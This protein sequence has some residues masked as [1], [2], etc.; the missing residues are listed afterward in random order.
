MALTLTSSPNPS[1]TYPSQG[2]CL[3]YEWDDP[4]AVIAGTQSLGVIHFIW[5][6]I[7]D[8]DHFYVDGIKFTYRTIVSDPNTEIEIDGGDPNQT[9]LNTLSVLNAASTNFIFSPNMSRIVYVSTY[10]G[11]RWNTAIDVSPMYSK[12]DFSSDASILAGTD[13]RLQVDYSIEL[14]ITL[15]G[16]ALGRYR[17]Y[18]KLIVDSCSTVDQL[19]QNYTLV[20][21][22]DIAEIIESSSNV[23][24]DYL[25]DQAL[26]EPVKQDNYVGE[27]VLQYRRYYVDSN[28]DRVLG[29][30]Q[31]A[32]NYHVG[33]GLCSESGEY[34]D[35]ADQ[36]IDGN[37][38]LA[39]WI[40][41][42][43][44]I[45]LCGTSNRPKLCIYLP[46]VTDYGIE[47]D[48]FTVGCTDPP[49]TSELLVESCQSYNFGTSTFV[50]FIPTFKTNLDLTIV[51]GTL[52]T[53]DGGVPTAPVATSWSTKSP[54]GGEFKYFMPSVQ[55][56]G[57]TSGEET[58]TYEL[59]A[60]SGCATYLLQFQFYVQANGPGEPT[61]G[62]T[63]SGYF[64]I[65]DVTP[66]GNFW[67]PDVSTDLTEG[68]HCFDLTF[69]SNKIGV[70]QSATF[71]IVENANTSATTVSEEIVISR[72][73]H[74]TCCCS[75]TFYFLS[76]IGSYVPITLTCELTHNIELSGPSYV[77]CSD[78]HPQDTNYAHLT[79][80]R[81][82]RFQYNTTY[83]V[84][85]KYS[86]LPTPAT[87]DN[88][89]HFQD[90]LSS[91]DI[92]NS[93]GERVYIKRNERGIKRES[94]QIRLSLTIYKAIRQ[95]SLN[96][97]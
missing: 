1:Y 13:T 4:D 7:V 67:T 74:I 42:T 57:G 66:A 18:P 68:L 16:C 38:V 11:S 88:I 55:S 43:N 76:D 86:S 40:T 73:D 63:A 34:L 33:Y 47:I 71:S 48:G 49:P 35:I 19:N 52:T 45:V 69:L 80:P 81:T 54:S 15:G 9:R 87:E 79:G 59:T 72:S 77:P 56:Y 2:C 37:S 60:T 50:Q 8:G 23:Y 89:L 29:Q 78:C 14:D 20:M 5:A 61:C 96:R 31:F 62:T 3:K 75:E 36:L 70:G 84:K 44:E 64:T 51:S 58:F 90:F 83:L 91:N 85:N 97:Y 25:L 46:D 6:D 27:V 32:P 30:F 82:E 22:Y 53:A 39:K 65:T 24:T 17:V 12:W 93:K 94:G 28:G 10:I 95:R 21:D 92:I 26:P 41:R